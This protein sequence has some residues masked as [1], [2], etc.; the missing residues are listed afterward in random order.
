MLGLS[1]N[2]RLS[3]KENY[4]PLP[5][6]QFFT[7][8]PTREPSLDTPA[9]D[10]TSPIIEYNLSLEE[11][12]ERVIAP[13]KAWQ[14]ITIG[15]RAIPFE[16]IERIEIRAEGRDLDVSS[17]YDWVS[18]FF[19]HFE[20]NGTDVT[21]EFMKDAPTWGPKIGEPE[22]PEAIPLDQ[23]FDRLVTNE[24]LREATRIRFRSQNFTDAV[25]AAFKCLASAVKE[26]SG[27][28]ERDGAELMRHVFGTSSPLLELNAR[29]S[30]SEKDEHDG[31]RDIFAGVMIG[32]RNPRAHEHA[33]KDNPAVAL[34]LL[35]M[36][37]H[38]MRKLE[39]AT[40]YGAQFEESTP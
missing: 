19:R 25:E 33:I 10:S 6:F 7:Q 3:W 15:G 23:M 36:A 24:L 35:T 18:N 17:R 12:N 21:R 32:I 13:F 8:T 28:Y 22:R 37:N 1:Y 11:L 14:E 40:Q 30:R 27:H 4:I 20:W 2:V 31:Y 29:G 26:K 9:V 5:R 39:N 38:L 34:E 16:G